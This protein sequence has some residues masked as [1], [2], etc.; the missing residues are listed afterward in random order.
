[1]KKNIYYQHKIEN[2]IHITDIVTIHYFE[3]DKSF[4]SDGEAHN[5]WEIV[6]ADKDDIIVQSADSITRLKEGH[7]IFHKPMEF[8]KLSADKSIPPNVFIIS[9]VCNS[10]A[11]SFFENK[12]FFIPTEIRH[13]ISTI[14][15]EAKQTFDIPF[16]NPYMKKLKLLPTPNLGGQQMI[17]TCLEQFL[18]M[19]IRLSS[20]QNPSEVFVQSH[21]LE[22]E[23]FKSIVSF[24]EENI[25]SDISLDDICKRTNYGKTFLC[26]AFRKTAGVS[27]MQY[28]LNMKISTAKK[29]IREKKLSFAQISERLCFSNPSYFT[30]VFKEHTRM[31][32]S[33]YARAVC[34]PE[35]NEIC[36]NQISK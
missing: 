14:I 18:I 4:E 24:L 23:L 25:F 29:M 20:A 12:T 16:F 9:F 5:F 32:P 21:L 22:S 27:I 10:K 3:F 8:H 26:T 15:S 36:N 2:L 19:L 31:T 6:Y 35:E 28:Y 1:M 7:M 30:R 34:V 11:M 13:Y 17:R 33:Q